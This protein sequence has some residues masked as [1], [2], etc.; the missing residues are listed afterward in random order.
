MPHCRFLLRTQPHLKLRHPSP[1]QLPGNLRVPPLPTE[2]QPTCFSIRNEQPEALQWAQPYICVLMKSSRHRI[3]PQQHSQP[4]LPMQRRLSCPRPRSPSARSRVKPP[5]PHV[6]P[7]LPRLPQ[8][9]AC[10]C[11]NRRPQENL[12][13]RAAIS[14]R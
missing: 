6:P 10:S 9:S 13:P 4:I 7:H 1:L 2:K 8:G 14:R 5:P 12:C 11:V 3:Q